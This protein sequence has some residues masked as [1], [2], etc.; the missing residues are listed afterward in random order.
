MA[1]QNAVRKHTKSDSSATEQHQA[2]QAQVP[3]PAGTQMRVVQEQPTPEKAQKQA[4]AQKEAEVPHSTKAPEPSGKPQSTAATPQKDVEHP[5][6]A[7]TQS[8]VP[9]ETPTATAAEPSQKAVVF[10]TPTAIQPDVPRVTPP[11]SAAEPHK[12][13]EFPT[14]ATTQPDVL[15]GTPPTTA[16]EPPQKAVQA[17]GAAMQPQVSPA[18]PPPTGEQSQEQ[19]FALNFD[20]IQVPADSKATIKIYDLDQPATPLVSVPVESGKPMTVH[21]TKRKKHRIELWVNDRLRGAKEE[22]PE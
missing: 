11:A 3:D 7:A 22:I 19:G 17:T 6:A 5:S 8:H 16:A 18:T 21:V 15:P 12:V 14:P 1:K 2:E 13:V 20:A 9:P 4:K 10:P